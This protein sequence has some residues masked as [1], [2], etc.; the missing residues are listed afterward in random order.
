MAD[1]DLLALPPEEAIAYLQQ[2]GYRFSWRWHEMWQEAHARAFTVAKAMRLDLLQDIRGELERAL[3]KG[4]TFEEFKRNLTPILQ[5]KGWWGRQVVDGESVQLGSPRR[6]ATIFNVNVQTAY[7][8][9]HYRHMTDPD[10]LDA[11]PYWRYVAVNDSRTR[12]AHRR[13]HNT[14]LRHDHPWWDTHYPPCGWSCRCRAVSMSEREMKRGGYKVTQNPDMRMVQKTDPRTG[15]SALFPYGIDPGWDYNPG[16]AY[17]NWENIK[18][19]QPMKALPGQPTW[20]DLGRPD[21]RGIG[22]GMRSAAPDMLPEA[23]SLDAAV[24][25][26]SD[27]LGMPRYQGWVDIPTKD[28][29][30]AVVQRDLLY[31][32]VA[33]RA[34]ARERYANFILPTLQDPFEIWLTDYDD[35]LRKAYIG[36]FEGKSDLL[37]VVKINRDG[38]IVWNIMQRDDRRMNSLRV[39]TMLYGK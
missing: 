27:A 37:V 28:D 8:V 9:G 20:Q 1:I 4:T 3:M 6:L 19:T 23:K 12:P 13:W 14:V 35:G 17:L 33:K 39:G 21:L 16:K 36:V 25:Q 10:V 15:K 38:S 7:S 29:D 26:L 2:K 30:L 18:S 22:Q 31:R 24:E 32:M 34:D 11:R 5:Q